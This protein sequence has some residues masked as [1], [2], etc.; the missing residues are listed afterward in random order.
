MAINN[1]IIQSKSSFLPTHI[2][3][4]KLWLDAH[5][6][7][8][9]DSGNNV[10]VWADSSG[11]GNDAMQLTGGYQPLWVD[12]QLN[13]K[14]V[15]RF[16]GSNDFMEFASG[17]MYNWTDVSLFIVLK[18][19][20]SWNGAVLGKSTGWGQSIQ[21]Y[22]AS[23][24]GYLNING[25]NLYTNF[26]LNNKYAISDFVYNNTSLN[27]YVNGIPLGTLAGGGAVTLNDVY[28]LGKYDN[29]KY[30]AFDVAEIIIYNTSLTDFS[31]QHVENYLKLKYD[32]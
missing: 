31:R 27:A 20:Y 14:P 15:L 7:V 29:N 26:L 32:L 4:C 28:A 5:Q 22:S 9:K 18:H 16:D 19:P 1:L 17:F 21:I 23:G 8:T 25:S 10:S 3:G 2:S 30:A 13:V 11:N 6:N 24:H 12:N